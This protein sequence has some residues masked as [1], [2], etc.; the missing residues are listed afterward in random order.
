KVVESGARALVVEFVLPRLDMVVD[1]VSPRVFLPA[2][3][4]RLNA[5]VFTRFPV[6]PRLVQTFNTALYR[7]LGEG[8]PIEA[9]VHQA[10]RQLHRTPLLGDAA[11]F[12]W[13]AL[14]TGPKAD[15]QLRPV[16]PVK[17]VDTGP[18]QAAAPIAEQPAEA[19]A[20]L[21]QETFSRE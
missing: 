10:R 20:G 9:A 19:P 16:R 4:N 6:H 1:P 2:L 17:P 18:K 3:S 8:R 11:G 14:V 7:E 13:F 15:L 21:Q 12:G 5:I